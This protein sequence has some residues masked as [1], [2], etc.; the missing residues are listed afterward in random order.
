MKISSIFRSAYS[1]AEEK[2]LIDSGATANFLDQRCH[3]FA[4]T[5]S[6]SPILYPLF[7]PH[8]HPCYCY[9]FLCHHSHPFR[10]SCLANSFPSAISFLCHFIRCFR[11]LRLPN[12]FTHRSC[13][14]IIIPSSLPYCA[15]FAVISRTFYPPLAY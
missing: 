6:L 10:Q 15:P 14:Y 2:V 12:P 8:F 9:F 11:Q 7:H 3:V 5:L 1:M 13:T 4:S